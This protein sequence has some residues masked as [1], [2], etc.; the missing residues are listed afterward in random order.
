MCLDICLFFSSFAWNLNFTVC[1]VFLP[2]TPGLGSFLSLTERIHCYPGRNH[3][4]DLSSI[5]IFLILYLVGRDAGLVLGAIGWSHNHCLLT[6]LSKSLSSNSGPCSDTLDSKVAPA[7]VPPLTLYREPGGELLLKG[8]QH[9]P[10]KER[11]Y[12][13]LVLELCSSNS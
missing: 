13:A 8:I 7:S 12:L 4:N 11:I 9:Q 1:A 3:I 5:P 6:V 10:M 2:V